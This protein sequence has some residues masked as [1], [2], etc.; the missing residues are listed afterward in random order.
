MSYLSLEGTCSDTALAEGIKEVQ[1]MLPGVPGKWHEPE[2]SLP[3][4]TGR[5]LQPPPAPAAPLHLNRQPPDMHFINSQFLQ[6][7][8]HALSQQQAG[9][10][11]PSKATLI[12]TR[13]G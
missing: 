1:E 8:K 10:R 6:V 12:F 3:P 4:K 2:P 11:D 9:Q 7:P 13:L 5:K